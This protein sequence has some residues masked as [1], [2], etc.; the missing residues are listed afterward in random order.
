[1][2]SQLYASIL[3]VDD[4]PENLHVMTGMLRERGYE[5]R[6]VPNAKLALQAARNDP[7]DLVLLD[8]N[9]P[10][11]NGYD[12]CQRLKEDPRMA[13]IPVVFVSA[14]SQAIDKVKAFAIGGVDYLTKPVQLEEL[15]ARVGTHLRI[16]RLQLQLEAQTRHLEKLVQAQVREISDSQVA[17]IMALAK[18]SEYRDEETGRHIHRV[19]RYCRALAE[20]LAGQDLMGA[21]IDDAF[22]DNI[23][24]AAAMHDI[25]KVGIPD[26]ILLKPGR[27]TADEIEIIK[28][29]CALGARALV[30]VADQYPGN[31]FASM[32]AEIA[33]SHHERWDGTGYPDGLAGEAIPLSARITMLADQ[34]D[35]L[36]SRRPYKPPFD[37]DKTY[38]V[39]T[40]G[41][42][43]TKPDH[44]DPRV[45]EAFRSIA[46]SFDA[47]HEE[48]RD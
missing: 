19:Q 28:G 1:M 45:L 11:M 30:A 33:R 38:A 43:R 27:L 40:Q 44:F 42:G 34:Y 5:A 32:G 29:H 6:P 46:R 17:T 18:L 8:I 13:E 24:H 9:M 10:D 41:D 20:R 4:S 22:I 47:I 31:A 12:L 2:S 39:I 35:A 15:E 21:R 25:G 16:R 23:Y 7:P 3:V 26:S 36:R 37:R 48:L 14:N